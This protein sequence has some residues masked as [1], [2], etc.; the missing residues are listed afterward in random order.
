M[1]KGTPQLRKYPVCIIFLKSLYYVLF[2]LHLFLYTCNHVVTIIVLSI[3][4]YYTTR[5]LK[6]LDYTRRVAGKHHEIVDR[7]VFPAT[8]RV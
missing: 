4:I 7:V 1:L 8:R 5:G 3:F 2:L 6:I